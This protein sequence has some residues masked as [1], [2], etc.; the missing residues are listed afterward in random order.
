VKTELAVLERINAQQHKS[1]WP[2]LLEGP[3]YI[4]HPLSYPNKPG[5][6]YIYWSN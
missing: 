1:L 5:D 4:D 6:E 3:I 2:S